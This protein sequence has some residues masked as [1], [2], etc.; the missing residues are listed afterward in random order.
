MSGKDKLAP[1]ER[2][3][4]WQIDFRESKDSQSEGI[5]KIRPGLV[6]GDNSINKKRPHILVIPLATGGGK[7][8]ATPPISISVE[9][10]SK[11]GIALIDQIMPIKKD[12]FIKFNGPVDSGDL[13]LVEQ[14][15]RDVLKL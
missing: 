14:A 15:L 10:G 13:I 3:D 5:N 2:G 1:P 8:E 12:R 7:A 6:I 11:R 9:S 4:I